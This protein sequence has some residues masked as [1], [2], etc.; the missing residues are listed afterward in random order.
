MAHCRFIVDWIRARFS[1]LTMS[2]W[3]TRLWRRAMLEARWSPTAREVSSPSTH[4]ATDFHYPVGALAL[5]PIRML[6]CP[7]VSDEEQR[8]RPREPVE[9]PQQHADVGQQQQRRGRQDPR[10]DPLLLQHSLRQQP[11]T[12]PIRA[13]ASQTEKGI[14]GL[15][16]GH[17]SRP[18]SRDRV[19]V[20]CGCSGARGATAARAARRRPS[21]HASERPPVH[22]WT[23]RGGSS[24]A[25]ASSHSDS[26]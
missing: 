9:Q 18:L 20:Y 1:D 14:A 13:S 8:G 19:H 21:G 16:Q 5:S 15:S 17:M 2:M 11:G 23:R 22:A 6:S 24:T 26:R 25:Y 10:Q 7:C 4:V 12:R 3:C